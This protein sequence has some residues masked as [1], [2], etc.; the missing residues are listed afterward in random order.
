MVTR[1]LSPSVL[2]TLLLAFV[3]APLPAAP[4][5]FTY[6]YWANNLEGINTIGRANR[7]G[8]ASIRALSAA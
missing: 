7:M 5:T 6:L 4:G 3:A 8:R 2:L 1:W